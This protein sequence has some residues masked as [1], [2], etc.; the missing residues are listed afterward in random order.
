M[1]TAFHP[2]GDNYGCTALHHA[3]QKGHDRVATLLLE[4]GA[5]AVQY[6]NDGWAPFHSACSMGNLNIAKMM[7]RLFSGV[8]FLIGSSNICLPHN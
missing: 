6:N 2:P 1:N 4:K 5:D 7:V 8:T 3:L